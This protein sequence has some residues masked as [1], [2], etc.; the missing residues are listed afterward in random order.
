[1]LSNDETLDLHANLQNYFFLIF[2]S[3]FE[4]IKHS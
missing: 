1:M 4:D 3:S 2:N